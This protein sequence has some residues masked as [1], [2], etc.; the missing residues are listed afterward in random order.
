M[1]LLGVVDIGGTKI[2]T[3]IV[4]ER[5]RVVARRSAPTPSADGPAAVLALVAHLLREVS[6]DAR[7]HPDGIGV[8]TAGVVN[9]H[10]G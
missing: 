10:T 4:D 9:S 5:F 8:G 2:A 1:G 6:R 3:G 7:L